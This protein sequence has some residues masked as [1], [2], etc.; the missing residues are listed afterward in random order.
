MA[1]EVFM[2]GT[3]LMWVGF[4]AALTGLAVWVT[5]ISAENQIFL[6]AVLTIMSVFIWRKYFKKITV[7]DQP[8]LNNRGAQL[9][10]RSFLLDAPI[11]NGHGFL[12]VNDTRWKI[13]GE[14]TPAGEKVKV[15]FVD[16]AILQVEKG[17]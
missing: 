8:Y 16:G 4:A 15:I 13:V 3:F 6:F 12:I 11:E 9:V 1:L 10:G 5:E 17:K 7:S 2:P 14:D